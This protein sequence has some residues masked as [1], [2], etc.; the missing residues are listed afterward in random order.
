[1]VLK[2][3][4]YTNNEKNVGIFNVFIDVTTRNRMPSA[5]MNMM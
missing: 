1:M 5:T 3:L 4:S 2:F